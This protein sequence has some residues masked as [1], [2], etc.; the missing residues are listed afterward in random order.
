MNL[1]EIA[2][3]H[4]KAFDEL[5]EM[6]GLTEEIIK[7]TLAPLTCDF[8]SKSLSLV[9]FFRNIEEEAKAIRAAEIAMAERR[10]ALEH[11]AERLKEYLKS[12]M[13]LTGIKNIKCAY[14][15]VTLSE[16]GK[17]VEIVD[18]NKIPKEYMKEKT[19][20]TPDKDAIKKAGGCEG[21]ELRDVWKL[22][23]K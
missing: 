22:T 11:K 1:Y 9:S 2:A 8:E 13:I 6:D 12:N 14:F 15:S 18:T 5:S 7:D 3:E 4:K 16:G 17:A 23:I 20:Y 21:A 19:T 10:K